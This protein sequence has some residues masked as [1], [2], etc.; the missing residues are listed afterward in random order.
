MS[1]LPLG[2]KRQCRVCNRND[3]SLDT[4][5]KNSCAVMLFATAHIQKG[6]FTPLIVFCSDVL[7]FQCSTIMDPSVLHANL[8]HFSLQYSTVC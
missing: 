7:H 2:Q 5:N 4:F 3:I 8:E 1:F 6:I